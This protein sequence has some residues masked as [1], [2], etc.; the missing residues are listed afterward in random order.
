VSKAVNDEDNVMKSVGGILLSLAALCL[1]QDGDQ[2]VWDAIAPYEKTIRKVS[3]VAE[4]TV[5]Q[6]KGERGVLIRVQ[7]GEARDTVRLL[8][9]NGQLGG[10]PV[11][12]YVGTV[13]APAAGGG[14]ARCPVHCG[15]GSTVAS[16]GKGGPGDPK[17][18]TTRLD[19]PTYA[20]ERCDILRKWLG[21]PK[22]EEGNVR[23]TE[24]VSTSNNPARIKWAISQGFPHWRSQEMPTGRGSDAAGVP[25]PEHGVHSQ[26]EMVCYTW[27]RHRQFCPLGAK[28]VLKEIDDLSPSQGPRK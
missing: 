25:C 9:S 11:L 21:L 17:V 6:I 7:T 20:Q 1:A 12:V 13:T 3:G 18:D 2:E 27:I 23:C 5:G 19:D 14:C 28:Q 16:P 15:P 8:C 24:M 10:Y 22:L 26:G 4:I